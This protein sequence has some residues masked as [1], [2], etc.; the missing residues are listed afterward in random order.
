[1]RM[2]V[3]FIGVDLEEFHVLHSNRVTP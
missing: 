3:P 2:G 1:M